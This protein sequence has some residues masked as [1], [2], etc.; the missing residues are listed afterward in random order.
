[1]TFD[2]WNPISHPRPGRYTRGR[3]HIDYAWSEWTDTLANTKKWLPDKAASENIEEAFAKEWTFP[4]HDVS[5]I[6]C[7]T[8]P[9][10]VESDTS[11]TDTS[12]NNS[13]GA[14]NV[15]TAP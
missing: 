15:P 3:R 1:M 6:A 5:D 8:R 7:E 13:E 11:T 2:Y 4:T 14:P 9:E 12:F 10:V